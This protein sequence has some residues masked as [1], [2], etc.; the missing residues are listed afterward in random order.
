MGEGGCTLP[1]FH[2]KTN[3]RLGIDRRGGN[4]RPSLSWAATETAGPQDNSWE[5][6]PS[7]T[8]TGDGDGPLEE[9]QFEKVGRRRDCLSKDASTRSIAGW[10]C[11]AA[12]CC[13]HSND[14]EA[15]PTNVAV[16]GVEK[17]N[18]G[19]SPFFQWTEVSFDLSIRARFLWRLVFKLLNL[20]F[21]NPKNPIFIE[22]GGGDNC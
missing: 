10:L 19:G 6:D 11:W 1:P 21:S 22:I 2:G 7:S 8:M 4:N 13:R 15:S 17:K 5:W 18:P 12:N 16:D 9:K 3:I 20:T 14:K